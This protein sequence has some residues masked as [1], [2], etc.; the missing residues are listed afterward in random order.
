MKRSS[1]S[2]SPSTDTTKK[3]KIDDTNTPLT[4]LELIKRDLVLIQYMAGMWP[5]THLTDEK[6]INEAMKWMR[7]SQIAMCSIVRDM[8]DEDKAKELAVLSGKL[9]EARKIVLDLIK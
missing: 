9:R 6:A 7:T 2:S 3:V 4:E 8:S 5:S 1:P